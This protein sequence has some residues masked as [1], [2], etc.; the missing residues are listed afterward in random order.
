MSN[1]YY[2]PGEFGLC[3]LDSIDEP[4]LC[5][6]YNTMI[7][8]QHEATGRVFYAQNSGCSCPTPFED[9]YFRGPDDTD[10]TEV[11]L[12]GDSLASFRADA[13]RFPVDTDSQRAFIKSVEDALRAAYPFKGG[14]PFSR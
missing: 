9:F 6:E 2:T 7:A 1:V 5:Y 4:N 3:L 10:L 12:V 11:T 14:T 13:E 8:L